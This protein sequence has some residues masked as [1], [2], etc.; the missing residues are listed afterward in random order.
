MDVAPSTTW[1]FVTTVPS[2]ESTMPVPAAVPLASVDVISTSPDSAASEAT[3]VSDCWV[4]VPDEP[5]QTS[6]Y[7]W[8][9]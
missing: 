1:W 4:V 7:P 5:P 2:D 6:P 3:D 9:P 8:S